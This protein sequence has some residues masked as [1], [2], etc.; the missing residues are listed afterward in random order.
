[1]PRRL[2]SSGSRFEAEVGYSRAVVDDDWVFELRRE[3][4]AR[5]RAAGADRAA[6][7]IGSP[8]VLER[9][10]LFVGRAGE[11]ARLHEAWRFVRDRRAR[12]LLLLAGEPGVGKTR[13]A[14]RFASE[15]GDATVLVGRCSEDPLTAFEYTAID[16]R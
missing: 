13:L 5:L 12:R 7:A 10:E 2:I 14:L 8:A 4:E 9:D 1:M 6:A 3:Y 15:A 16:K 11:L